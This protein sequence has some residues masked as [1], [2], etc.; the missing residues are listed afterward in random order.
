MGLERSSRSHSAICAFSSVGRAMDFYRGFEPHKAYH[1]ARVAQA[2]E[3]R[4]DFGAQ[5]HRFDSGRGHLWD[6]SSGGRAAD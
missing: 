4:A 6:L 2:V 1:Y 5:S 3:Q